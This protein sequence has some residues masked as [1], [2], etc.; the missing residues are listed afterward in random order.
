M[1][2]TD[3]LTSV[4][5]ITNEDMDIFFYIGD[6][7]AFIPGLRIH[8]TIAKICFFSTSIGIIIINYWYTRKGKS[9]N[10]LKPFEM[11][12]GLKTP[13]E[14]GIILNKNK[15]CINI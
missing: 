3:I 7:T 13:K 5:F 12:S 1:I 8:L 15:I 11:M 10:W 4:M 14:I 2:L 6:L 9:H